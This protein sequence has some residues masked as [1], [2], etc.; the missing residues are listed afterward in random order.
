MA[1]D[2]YQKARK[3]A[4]SITGELFCRSCNANRKVINGGV[5]ILTNNGRNRRWKC[6]SCVN[7]AKTRAAA[8]TASTSEDVVDGHSANTSISPQAAA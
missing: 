1:N 3:A 4:T 6:Q 5:W 8:L 2:M 7:A